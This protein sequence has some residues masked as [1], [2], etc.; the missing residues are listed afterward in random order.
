MT[1]LHVSVGRSNLWGSV[2]VPLR[3]GDRET[4]RGTRS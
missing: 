3:G 4:L 1:P 2:G